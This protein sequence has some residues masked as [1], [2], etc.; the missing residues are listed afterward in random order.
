MLQNTT[1][2]PGGNYFW[3]DGTTLSFLP[4]TNDSYPYDFRGKVQHIAGGKGFGHLGPEYV[5]Y[6]SFPD[7]TTKDE[8][9]TRKSLG[10]YKNISL[11]GSMDEVDWLHLI[12]HP[13]YSDIVDVYEGG[14]EFIR[15]VFRS[16]PIS[17]MNSYIPYFNAISRQAIVER[18]MDYANIPFNINEFY[19]N[20]VLEMPT[21]ATRA[22]IDLP[23]QTVNPGEHITSVIIGDKPK[24]KNN[25]K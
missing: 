2:Y 22:S 17:C 20:D 24:L 16:E 5:K 21:Q 6:N 11:I 15:G 1:E 18:I 14:C 12:F 9:R 25:N 3:T 8:I 4:M 13:T 23:Q 10:W 7:E 19:A